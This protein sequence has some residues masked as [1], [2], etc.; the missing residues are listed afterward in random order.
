MAK[1]VSTSVHKKKWRIRDEMI[2]DTIMEMV[3][4]DP[5][6]LVRPEQIAMQIRKDDWQELLKRIRL[7]VRKLALEGYINIIRKGEIADPDDFKG[8]Y[9]VTAGPSATGYQPRM[10][11]E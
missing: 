9:R 8:V 1:P 4:V 11:Q 6:K 10:P 2:Y 3:Q 7:F 5:E